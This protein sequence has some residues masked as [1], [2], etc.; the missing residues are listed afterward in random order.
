LTKITGI[1]LIGSHWNIIS[2]IIWIKMELFGL[3]LNYLDKIVYLSK[4][5]S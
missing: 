3:N 2:G 1:E 4:E 5:V